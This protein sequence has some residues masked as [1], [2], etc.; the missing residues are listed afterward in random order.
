MN[1]PSSTLA[2]AF[3]FKRGQLCEDQHGWMWRWDGERFDLLRIGDVCR[4][5]R[6]GRHARWQGHG[7]RELLIEEGAIVSVR[8]ARGDV[9]MHD[10]LCLVEGVIQEFRA[11]G[12]GLYVVC[13]PWP[14]GGD[15]VEVPI[16]AVMPVRGADERD[17]RRGTA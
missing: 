10:E 17:G 13:R 15:E 16:E 6:S 3:G 11:G 2:E 12:E 14:D 4:D 1:R 8:Y 9:R 7:W 5:A